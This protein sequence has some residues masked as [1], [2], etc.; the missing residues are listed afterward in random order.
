MNEALWHVYG[1]KCI[2]AALYLSTKGDDLMPGHRNTIINDP[3]T[4]M[5]LLAGALKLMLDDKD[6]MLKGSLPIGGMT[7]ESLAY[8]RISP[9]A[10]K[11]MERIHQSVTHI[12]QIQF[13]V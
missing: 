9:V 4:T 13:C 10:T 7:K 3:Q 8:T 2:S 5:D 12:F 1:S 11:E 6:V